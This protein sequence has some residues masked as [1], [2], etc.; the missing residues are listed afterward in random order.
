MSDR[1]FGRERRGRHRRPGGVGQNLQ[2]H[3]E[4]YIQQACIQP[5]IVQMLELAGQKP[6]TSLNGS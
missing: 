3:L 5:I 4:L 1:T 6:G 2:D